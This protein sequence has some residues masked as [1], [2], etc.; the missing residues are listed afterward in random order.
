MLSTR[1]RH[2]LL[3]DFPA[4]VCCLSFI[5]NATQD[6]ASTETTKTRL[7][8]NHEER[9]QPITTPTIASTTTLN[10]TQEQLSLGA[11]DRLSDVLFLHAE[12]LFESHT[13]RDAYDRYAQSS[14]LVPVGK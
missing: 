1:N 3:A 12:A 14:N 5:I 9:I 13:Y 11:V 2:V 4:A 8:P 7:N 10:N 6:V